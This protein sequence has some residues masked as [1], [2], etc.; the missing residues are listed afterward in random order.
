MP[1]LMFE[2]MQQS[3]VTDQAAT[4]TVNENDSDEAITDSP[5]FMGLMETLDNITEGFKNLRRRLY[6][7]HH[8]K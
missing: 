5:S 3:I 2:I 8:C 6:F 1:Q 7:R 4:L